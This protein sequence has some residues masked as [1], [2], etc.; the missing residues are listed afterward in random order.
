MTTINVDWIGLYNYWVYILLMMIGL[1]AVMAKNNLVK[2]VIGLGIFQTAVFLFYIS[3]SMVDDG[4]VPIVWDLAVR[5]S[6]PL[7]HVLILT[8]IVVA[9]STMAV[10]LALVIAIKHAY[11]TIE[12][13]ELDDGD[14][15]S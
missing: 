10:A 3:M 13:N 1:Y 4:T 9:V 8:A 5:Y 2:K 14:K 11:G 15:P 7:P 6:N 12:S